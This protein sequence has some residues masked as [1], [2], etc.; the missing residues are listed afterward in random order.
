MIQMDWAVWKI[1]KLNFYIFPGSRVLL[2]MDLPAFVEPLS[3]KSHSLSAKPNCASC[4]WQMG[5][6]ERYDDFGMDVPLLL[7]SADPLG[8][9]REVI[10]ERENRRGHGV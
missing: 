1:W 9:L 5:R 10:L 8:A 7:C 3:Y 2:R 6:A 4:I